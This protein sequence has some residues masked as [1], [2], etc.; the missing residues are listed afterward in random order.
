VSLFDMDIRWATESDRAALCEIWLS[1]FLTDTQEECLAFLDLVNLPTECLV[2][3]EDGTPISMAFLLPAT[4]CVAG[5]IYP[6][7]YVYAASTHA[8]HRGKGVFSRLLKDALRRQT[9][10]GVKAIVLSPQE[11]SLVQF[12]KRFG[13]EPFCFRKMVHG[14][15]ADVTMAIQ[16]VS[17][18]EYRA[19]RDV[20]LPQ[21]RIEWDDRFLN[22]EISLY[23]AVRVINEGYALCRKDGT[24]LHVA[25]RLGCAVSENACA[26]LAGFFDCKDYVAFSEGDD[27]D[28]F[29]MIVPLDKSVP[30]ENV[31]MGFSFG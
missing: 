17:H 18:T 11:P 6:I 31:Y 29:G 7:R 28:C 30:V 1:S 21:H 3:C 24:V 16:P 25:E 20:L 19:A 15:S 26:E 9:E 8:G 13:F 5:E 2:A 23:S 22:A 27:G 12:Y 4:L 10:N 14:T